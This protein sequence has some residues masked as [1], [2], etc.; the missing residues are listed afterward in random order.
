MP[1]RAAAD[2]FAVCSS[3]RIQD[4]I[5]KFLIIRHKVEFI[6]KNNIECRTSD[7]LWVIREGFDCAAICE[8][9]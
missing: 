6:T 9:D 3:Q 2:E 7:S 4:S 5:I 8:V 1:W